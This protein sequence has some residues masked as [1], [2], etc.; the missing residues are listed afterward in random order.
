M[1]VSPLPRHGIVVQGRDRP[2]RVLRVA[3]HPETG[4]LVLSVWQ[5]NTCQA[6]VRLSPAE[7]AQLVSALADALAESGAQG[8]PGRDAG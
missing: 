1:T 5:D 6:T 8:Q 4:R 2:G 7:I 3:S